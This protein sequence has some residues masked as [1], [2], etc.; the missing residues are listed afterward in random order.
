MTLFC[1]YY[2]SWFTDLWSWVVLDKLSGVIEHQRRITNSLE[3]SW[4]I[5]RQ[6]ATLMR[7]KPRGERH[8]R[9][10]T[11]IFFGSTFLLLLYLFPPLT[12]VIVHSTSKYLAKYIV[13]IR[14]VGVTLHTIYFQEK[15]PGT[16]HFSILHHCSVLKLPR[17]CFLKSYIFTVFFFKNF[18]QVIWA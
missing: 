5:W 13:Y 6:D 10:C 17:R 9:D 1:Q 15:K 3:I 14:G 16:V 18:K 8:P 11:S 7:D 12:L 2:T 4:G